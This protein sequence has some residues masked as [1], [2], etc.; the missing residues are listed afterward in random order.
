MMTETPAQNMDKLRAG[1][2][3]VYRDKQWNGPLLL[4]NS[5]LAND[6]VGGADGATVVGDGAGAGWCW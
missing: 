2:P 3:N 6:S 5:S 4:P 1:V